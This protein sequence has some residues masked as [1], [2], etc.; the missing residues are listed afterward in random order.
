MGT[1]KKRNHVKGEF[2]IMKIR[3]IE[4]WKNGD[5]RKYKF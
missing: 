5:L 2:G 4:T 3:K 1:W